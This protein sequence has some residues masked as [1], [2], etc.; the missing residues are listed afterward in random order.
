MSN[1]K[2]PE[3]V[4]VARLAFWI[5]ESKSGTPFLS[6]FVEFADGT[7][8]NCRLFKATEKR[9]D[10]SPDYF[11]SASVEEDSVGEEIVLEEYV[12]EEKKPRKQ[13]AKRTARKSSLDD[14]PF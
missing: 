3:Y 8:V 10:K 5:K 11:G 9:T 4:D 13:A 6:G 1:K 14:E 12:R 7:K 2:Y